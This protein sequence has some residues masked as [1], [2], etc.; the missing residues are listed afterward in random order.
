PFPKP[1]AMLIRE[2]TYARFSLPSSFLP[3]R[4]A[5]V[6]QD[7]L[8]VNLDPGADFENLFFNRVSVT[9]V[10]EKH[11]A[12]GPLTSMPYPS[13][14]FSQTILMGIRPYAHKA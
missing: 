5:I 14:A 2:K 11:A 6:N 10:S 13:R 4:L 9:I 8:T 12:R 3:C 1:P 7:A